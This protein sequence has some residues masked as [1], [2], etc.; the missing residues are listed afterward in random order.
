MVENNLGVMTE[1]CLTSFLNFSNKELIHWA[2][3]FCWNLTFQNLLSLFITFLYFQ[4]LTNILIDISDSLWPHRLQHA[5]LPCPSPNPGACS[6]LCPLSQGCNPTISSSVILSR[7]AINRSQHQDLFQSVSYS[8]KLAKILK[9][10]FQHQS[11]MNIQHWFALRLTG[12][13]S[14]Q[15]KGLSRVFSNTTVHKHQFFSAQLSLWPYLHIYTWPLD[16]L[17]L[18]P[19]GSLS[20]K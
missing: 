13:I 1:Y 15:F 14:L 8:H 2:F 10:W 6:N 7:P 18:W 16:K 12:L 4:I 20:A 3:I 9:F 5:R 11:S 17:W 19:D